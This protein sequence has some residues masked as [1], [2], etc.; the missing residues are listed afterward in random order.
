MEE[1]YKKL[2]IKGPVV[3]KAMNTNLQSSKHNLNA[4]PG[5]INP[6]KSEEAAPEGPENSAEASVSSNFLQVPKSD[7]QFRVVS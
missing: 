3:R 1:N 5:A 4:L 2:N 7:D 6:P